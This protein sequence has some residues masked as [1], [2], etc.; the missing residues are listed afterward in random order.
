MMIVMLHRGLYLLFVG[1]IY[2]P[3]RVY[4]ACVLSSGESY[5]AVGIG[6]R[7]DE[8]QREILAILLEIK[9]IYCD[10]N[11]KFLIFHECV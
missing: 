3:L 6:L 11:V 2:Q 10:L 1:W 5:H 9:L 7:V 8:P 4:V